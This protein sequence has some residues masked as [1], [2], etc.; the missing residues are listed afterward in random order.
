MHRRPLRETRGARGRCG[1]A[2]GSSRS[3]SPNTGPAPRGEDLLEGVEAPLPEVAVAGRPLRGFAQGTGIEGAMVLAAPHLA[4]DEPRS[5]EELEVL[6][7]RVQG[8]VEGG[9]DLGDPE[10]P[11][12]QPRQDGP[13]RGIG[14]GREGLAQPGLGIFNHWVE[15]RAA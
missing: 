7:Y 9:R 12:L 2:A 3:P 8:D 15:Y 11:L 10:G 5:L 13:A 1:G 4:A 6:G 14:E